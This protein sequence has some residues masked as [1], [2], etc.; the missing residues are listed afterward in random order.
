MKEM[1]AIAIASLSLCVIV[2]EF[3]TK[4][5][6]NMFLIGVGL[7][8]PCG[9]GIAWI[10]AHIFQRAKQGKPKGYIKQ[11]LLLWCADKKLMAPIYLRRSGKW[12]VG[13]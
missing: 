2:L 10:I 4:L 8:F 12:S 11:Y 13:K 3:L 9:V 7:A 6:L 5:L 1:Q